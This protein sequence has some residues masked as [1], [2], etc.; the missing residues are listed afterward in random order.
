MSVCVCMCTVLLNHFI[1]S[2][3][4]KLRITCDKMF[5]L[6]GNS[7]TL[8]I[9]VGLSRKLKHAIFETAHKQNGLSQNF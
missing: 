9:N 1:E 5:K 3:G 4:T 6:F 8:F 2:Y 7:V